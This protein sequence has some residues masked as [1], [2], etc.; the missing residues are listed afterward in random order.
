MSQWKQKANNNQGGE[1]DVPP[2]GSHPAILVAII[3]LGNKDES[4]QGRSYKAHKL[5]FVWELT[6]EKKPDIDDNFVIGQDYSLTLGKKSNLRKLIEGL[7][8]KPFGDD[9]EYDP[10]SL[11]GKP[12]LL[13]LV[14]KTSSNQNTFAQIANVTAVPKGMQVPKP[15]HKPFTWEMNPA[16]V[17]DLEQHNWLPFVYGTPVVDR[18][19]LADEYREATG[20]A[21]QK[22]Q[23]A[24]VFGAE[25]ENTVE[26]VG[27]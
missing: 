25:E 27:Y 9:E 11:L 2:A 15:K 21:F 26:T 13:T 5:F 20:Q 16:K 1:F 4:F 24:E 7:R 6:A 10:A 8:G 3:D 22:Q 23:E 17:K 12:M 18:I 14:H 19:K